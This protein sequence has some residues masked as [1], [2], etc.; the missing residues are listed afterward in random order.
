MSNW[1]TE[2]FTPNSSLKGADENSFDLKNEHFI[3]FKSSFKRYSPQSLRKYS[4][5]NENLKARNFPVKPVY[6][7]IQIKPCLQLG[8]D[9]KTNYW[10]PQFWDRCHIWLSQGIGK[11]RNISHE[12]LPKTNHEKSHTK[13]RSFF[14]TSP[15][16]VND[17]GASSNFKQ[18]FYVWPP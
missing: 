11:Q 18:D 15:K 13:L 3:H 16:T 6:S 2:P 4:A 7:R 12:T 5:A 1:A 9:L 8:M 17:N 14:V 10:A